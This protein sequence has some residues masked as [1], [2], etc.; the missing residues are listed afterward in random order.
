[1]RDA[2]QRLARG[3]RQAL[4][5]PDGVRQEVIAHLLDGEAPPG[6]VASENRS[7][8]RLGIS[9]DATLRAR[10]ANGRRWPARVTDVSLSGLGAELAGRPP[11]A[12]PVLVEMCLPILGEC[13]LLPGRISWVEEARS[14]V[15]AG[16]E[17][18]DECAW[19]WFAALLRIVN[20]GKQGAFQPTAG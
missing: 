1:M 3:L 16:V 17:L 8:G 15:R 14:G 10:E 19:P 13:H 2:D 11:E 12:G 20:D 18:A 5:D 6:D 4:Q 7:S 9:L